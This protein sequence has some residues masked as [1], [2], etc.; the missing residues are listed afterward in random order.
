MPLGNAMAGPLSARPGLDRVR[1]GCALVLFASAA[2]QPLI[3]GPRALSRSG[4][5]PVTA[6]AGA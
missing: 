2:S 6:P 4:A 5:E 1:V 3:P